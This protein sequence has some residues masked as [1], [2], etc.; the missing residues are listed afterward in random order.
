MQ[1]TTKLLTPRQMARPPRTKL[2]PAR[3]MSRTPTKNLE[4]ADA[5]AAASLAALLAA[6]TLDDKSTDSSV[7][8]R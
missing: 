6:M 2:V 3:Q 7:G 8:P 4:A 1:K 5:Q